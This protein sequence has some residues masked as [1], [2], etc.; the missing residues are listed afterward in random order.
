MNVKHRLLIIK[1]SLK[2][3]FLCQNFVSTVAREEGGC[4]STNLVKVMKK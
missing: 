3:Q 2:L 4:N 1:A